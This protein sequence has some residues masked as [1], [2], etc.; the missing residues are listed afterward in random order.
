MSEV[1]GRIIVLNDAE[2]V[3]AAGTFKKRLVVVE[4]DEQY[5]QKIGID[6]VQD[7][8]SILDKYKVGDNVKIS[9]NIRGQ[10][11]N[12]K[13]YVSLNGWRVEKQESNE[14]VPQPKAETNKE[15]SVY[16]EDEDSGLPF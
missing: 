13:Y 3:G 4:T 6:F 5:S 7:K 16:V 9:T 2:I 14:P 12:G 10:E 1:T 8:T 15:G 11:Y